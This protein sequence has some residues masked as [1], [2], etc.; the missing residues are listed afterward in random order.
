MKKD[1]KAI[2]QACSVLEQ[3]VPD[4]MFLFRGGLFMGIPFE[5]YPFTAQQRIVAYYYSELHTQLENT[6]VEYAK[7]LDADGVSETDEEE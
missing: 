6:M 4:P 2:E 7:S 1:K 5:H 3:Q